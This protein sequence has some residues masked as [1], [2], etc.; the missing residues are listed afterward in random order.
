MNSFALL[1]ALAFEPKKAFAAL[2]ERPRVLFP[3]VLLVVA[4]VGI[5]FWYFSVVDMPWLLDQ[6]RSGSQRAGR[7]SE[8]QRRTMRALLPAILKWGSLVTGAIWVVALRLLEAL[9][10]MLA[11]K[12]TNVQR[13]YKQW[14]ALAAWSSLP[15]VLGAIPAAVVLLT[16]TTT[17]FSQSDLQTLSLNALFFH[18][19]FGEPGYALL[20]QVGLPDFLSMLLAVLGV[21]VW[22]GRSW[23]FSTVFALLLSAVILGL[24]AAFTMGR[25]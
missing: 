5:L 13:S 2:A 6:A 20:S 1:Q 7:M 8:E 12:I 3:I 24:W 23:L 4:T 19:A 22:S 21:R 18:R 15:S 10:Y 11:G 17:Q 14:L 25:S 9:Y 16:T